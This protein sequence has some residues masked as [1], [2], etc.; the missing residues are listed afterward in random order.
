VPENRN[1]VRFSITAANTEAEVERALAA[2][3]AAKVPAR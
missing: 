3:R 1:L 2:L